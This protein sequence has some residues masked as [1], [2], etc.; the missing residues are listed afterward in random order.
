[1]GYCAS[2]KDVNYTGNYDSDQ[3]HNHPFSEA[4]E[5][6]L[7]LTAYDTQRIREEVSMEND[8]IAEIRGALTLYLNFINLF[9]NLLQLFGEKK[10]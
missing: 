6:F 3:P 1:M 8:G 10:D 2:D 5:I 9:L 4:I 7:G